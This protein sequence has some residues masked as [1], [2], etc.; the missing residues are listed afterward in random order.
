MH[1]SPE[2]KSISSSASTKQKFP[3]KLIDEWVPTN[4]PREI[5]AGREWQTATAAVVTN[6]ADEPR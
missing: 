6:D 5:A 1:I 2:A 3:K 4:S